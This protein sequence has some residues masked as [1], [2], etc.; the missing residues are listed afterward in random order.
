[1]L[2]YKPFVLFFMNLL[3]RFLLRIYAV[4]DHFDILQ[5]FAH[6]SPASLDH[7][8]NV[9]VSVEDHVLQKHVGATL[10]PSV[11]EVID[12]RTTCACQ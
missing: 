6:F 9:G 8:G 12:L 2:F 1:M 5:R 10:C 7:G 4:T 11:A 3:C